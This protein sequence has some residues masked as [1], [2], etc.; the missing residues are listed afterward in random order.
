MKTSNKTYEI[1][2][3]LISKMLIAM[4][5][6]IQLVGCG[7]SGESDATADINAMSGINT[8]HMVILEGRNF[9]WKTPVMREDSSPL[10][11]A[12]I[13]GFRV[14]YGTKQGDYVEQIDINDAYTDAITLQLTSGTYYLVVTTVDS[15]GRES[16][17][18]KEYVLT[19]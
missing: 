12:E 9:G 7:T 16:L 11:M 5:M 1:S 10:S 3:R 4:A 19:V 2:T 17:Y 8:T 13:S 15:D 18:S 6:I 14:Y